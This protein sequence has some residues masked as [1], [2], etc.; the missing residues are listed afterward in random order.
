MNQDVQGFFVWTTRTGRCVALL[1]A[2]AVMA[3]AAETQAAFT[4]VDAVSG[5]GGNTTLSGGGTFT[6][7]LNGAT[8]AD[9]N[10]EQRTTFGSSGNIYEAGGEASEDAPTLQTKISGLT[11]GAAYSV[12]VHFW[13]GSGADPDWN[14]RAGFA[15]GS[16][17]L[18]GNGVATDAVD[19]GA[20]GA[21][22][23]SDLTYTTA[24]TVFT[25]ADRTMFAGLVG[26]AV[27]DGSGEIAVYIDDLPSTIGA[28]NRTWYDGV[29]YEQVP[30]PSA[31]AL[32]MLAAPAAFAVRRTVG[33]K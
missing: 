32:L 25:E 13:D 2:T 18:F 14:V 20:T 10:W 3:I 16:L 15:S 26:N 6:P 22:L 23:A 28:N 8:G 30:E 27:A 9:N 21:G 19:L 1:A 5:V 33:L 24:P 4:Y 11:A 31:L 17:T 12:Y 7:P 29:S